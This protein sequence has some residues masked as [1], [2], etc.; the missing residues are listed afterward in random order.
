MAMSRG[1]PDRCYRSVF[2]VELAGTRMNFKR[3]C[4]LGAVGPAP[5]SSRFGFWIA[6]V[7]AMMVP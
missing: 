7:L 2:D 5:L 3:S 4:D 1:R 6:R